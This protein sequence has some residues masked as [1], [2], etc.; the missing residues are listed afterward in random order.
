MLC[1]HHPTC[2]GC[3]LLDQPYEGQL[4]AK[5]ARLATALG[6]YPHLHLPEVPPVAP[7]A[8]TEGYRHR[9]KLPIANR[10]DR[11]MVGLYHPETGHVVDT[12]DCPVLEPGLREALQQVVG[13]LRGKRGVH[14]IDLRRS[15]ATGDLQ[16][17]LACAGGELPGGPKGAAELLR[18]VPGLKSVA[19]SRADPHGKRVL[20]SG[21]RV[22][23]GDAWIEEA[24]G[25]TRYRLY[26][27]AFFQV[28][29]RNARWIHDRVRA[30]V[31]DAAT[32]LDLYAGVG[33]YALMLAPGRKRVLAVEE[34]TEAARSAR[35]MAPPN[36]EVVASKV[37]DLA[38]SEPFDVAILNP[39]RR[40]SD[41]ATLGR[42]AA[43]AQR[44]VYVS[45]GP[46]TLARDLDVLAAH[47]MR[48]VELG[49]VDL[50]P[51]TPEVETVVKL[52]R[53]PAVT[54]WAVT[55]GRAATPWVAPPGQRASKRANRGARPAA[56]RRPDHSG[57]VGT[58][59]RV[60]VLALG[61]TGPHGTLPGAR[62][63]R[64]GV[65]ATHSLL[66]IDLDGPLVPALAALARGGHPVAGRDP[67]T[68]WFF[69]DKVGLVRPFVHVEQSDQAL[70]PL[71]G[72]LVEA[73]IGLGA[74]P[75]VL[76]RAGAR[77]R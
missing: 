41:P 38:L 12:P 6:R 33:A 36:V 35:A 61:D 10:G 75:A 8:F 43:L 9:L 44:L 31:G 4:A 1:R 2:P 34:V 55:G 22:L 70:A 32:V 11:V 71:H 24:I 63:K 47:G 56:P 18:R 37:E 17:V 19:V 15:D 60:L 26:P 14:S 29:P 69:A 67:R 64:L 62:Y 7:A 40:G 25:P 30:Y 5:R 23:A 39:A 49:A 42:V 46:E 27:G 16:L 48:V 45:C 54:S 3:P 68:A 73:L 20:G 58:P 13:F 65:V 77:S 66:R 57:A 74:A 52:Q 50:F 21:P 28:D 76:D 53:G 51:N 59:R 72:D